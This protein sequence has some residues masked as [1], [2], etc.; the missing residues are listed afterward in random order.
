MASLFVTVDQPK[1]IGAFLVGFSGF[2]V[3]FLVNV[4][5]YGRS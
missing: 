4:F 1:R 3:C 2:V 5:A